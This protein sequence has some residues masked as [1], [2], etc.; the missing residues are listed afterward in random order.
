[1]TGV[2]SSRTI[3]HAAPEEREIEREKIESLASN[4]IDPKF[5]YV[6]P[7]QASL[8][9]QVFLQ[10]SPIHGNP[11]F[12]R[13]Y[14][15]A[16]AKVLD[17]FTAEDVWLVGLGCGTGSKE[18]ELQAALNERGRTTVFSAVDVSADLVSE[19]MNKL[20]AAGAGYR[21]SL[22]CDLQSS[23][24]KT[25]FDQPGGEI[26]R[27]IT[28]FGLVPNLAPSAVARIFQTALRPRDVLLVSAHLAP[29]RN[30]S[31]E[32]LAVAMKEVLPQYDNAET[33]TWITAGLEEWDLADRVH[34]PEITIGEL[35]GMPAFLGQ[36]RWKS[37]ELFEK[38]GHRFSP[39]VDEPLRLFYSLRYTPAL[40][41]EFLRREGFDF[42][43]LSITACRQEGIWVVRRK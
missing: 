24:L 16:F 25:W 21:R 32:D 8:W 11:E 4:R 36:A 2:E 19:S 12:A 5:L 30:E 27:L 22:V 33:L 6:T 3:L 34:A 43:M 37:G 31:P 26:P 17:I 41:E 39:A 13:I 35:E 1:M 15:D 28:F 29:V 42:E 23:F 7:R 18:K 14:R 20:L 38:W 9:R 40:F 10:H